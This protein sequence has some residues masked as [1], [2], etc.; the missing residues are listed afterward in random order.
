MRNRVCIAFFAA[1]LVLPASALAADSVTK[2]TI[3]SQGQKRTYYLFVPASASALK[4]MPLLVLLHGSGRNGLSLVDKWKDLASTDSFIIAGPNSSDSQG[5]RSPADGPDFLRDLIVALEAKY[6]INPRR[7]YLF[8]H[9]AGAV[10]ALNLSMMESEYFAA[11][12]VH[13]GSWRDRREFSQLELATRK[14]PVAIFVGDHDQFFSLTSVKAT[15]EALKARGFPIEVNI[16]KNHDHWYYDLAPQ[17]NRYAWEFLR[18]HEL[19]EDV[20]YASYLPPKAEGANALIEQINALRIEAND[21]IQRFNG[22]EA[23]LAKRDLKT[24]RIAANAIAREEVDLLEHSAAAVREAALK[25][26]QLSKQKLGGSYP[27]YF[28]LVAQLERRRGDV[29]DAMREHSQILLSDKTYE[30][31]VVQRNAAREKVEQL[32][33]EI[34]ELERK[35]ESVRNGGR[36]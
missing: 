1:V 18:Q 27:A 20:K 21:L 6:P 30:E 15:Q 8:G 24:E 3:N 25:A 22:R 36:P 32:Q 16:I 2:E 12:A 29:F 33:K 17:I 14:I 9:S 7:V 31:Q 4:P 26:E 23:E 13:A 35:A 28:S 11:T 34:A 19:K 5:W 10:F